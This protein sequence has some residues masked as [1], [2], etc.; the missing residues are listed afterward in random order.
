MI[1]QCDLDAA[2]NQ[3]DE[4]G[5]GEGPTPIAFYGITNTS[6]EI[7]MVVPYAGACVSSSGLSG[8]SIILIVFFITFSV[9]LIAG[10]VYNKL[11]LR[12]SGVNLIPHYEFWASTILYAVVS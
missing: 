11:A 5:P 9:Y 8:G 4:D 1:F 3:P 12:Q 6:C 10:V 2:W 7:R